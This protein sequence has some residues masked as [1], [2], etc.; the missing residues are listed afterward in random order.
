MNL[1][2]KGLFLCSFL[3]CPTHLLCWMRQSLQRQFS[4]LSVVFLGACLYWYAA[5]PLLWGLTNTLSSITSSKEGKGWLLL[6]G[7][8]WVSQHSCGCMLYAGIGVTWEWKG[9]RR[10]STWRHCHAISVQMK[11]CSGSDLGGDRA[12]P[13]VWARCGDHSSHSRVMDATLK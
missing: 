6:S 4:I 11:H 2:I 9:W 1:P 8:H 5:V 13:A 3:A 10:A 12:V 7:S